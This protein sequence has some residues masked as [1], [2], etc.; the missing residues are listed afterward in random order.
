MDPQ[1]VEMLHLTASEA[2]QVPAHLWPSGVARIT[3][4][5]A[6]VPLDSGLYHWTLQWQ[7]DEALRAKVSH[8]LTI[9]ACQPT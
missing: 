5:G 4:A 6:R 9:I 3:S 1:Q 7:R 8:G 2:A